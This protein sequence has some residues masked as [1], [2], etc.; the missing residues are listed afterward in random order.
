MTFTI[1]SCTEYICAYACTCLY[2]HIETLAHINITT[3]LLCRHIN[4]REFIPTG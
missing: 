3:L 1:T 4:Q 2:T